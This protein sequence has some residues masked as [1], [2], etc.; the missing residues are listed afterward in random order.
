[1]ADSGTN[2]S[3]AGAEVITGG[4]YSGSLTD[5]ADPADYYRFDIVAGRVIEVSVTSSSNEL[6]AY[7]ADA[8]EQW[9]VQ[10]EGSATETRYMTYQTAYE[11]T[12][13]YCYLKFETNA[14]DI[15]YSFSLTF[16]YSMEGGNGDAPA[17]RIDAFGVAEGPVM[18]KVNS[19]SA[20][21]NNGGEDGMDCYKFWAGEGDRINLS[22][23]A[24]APGL[25]YLN[26]LDPLE[27][28]LVQDLGTHS[29]MTETDEWWTARE[30][31]M[32]YY[33]LEVY[34]DTAPGEYTITLDIMKQDD[35]GNGTD[36][37]GEYIYGLEVPETT[38]I[39]HLEDEDNTDCYVTNAG[40]GDVISVEFRGFS[41]GDA[42]YFDLLDGSGNI[43]RSASSSFADSGQ[44][45]LYYT[46]N[47][48]PVQRYSLKVWMDTE[49][50][51]YVITLGVE[52]QNDA[53]RG[54][55]TPD[56]FLTG[57]ALDNGSYEGWIFDLDQS[58]VYRI[59]AERG[60]IIDINV[61]V[62]DGT[63]V[64]AVIF[65]SE[66][67]SVDSV[68]PNFGEI[69]SMRYC[70]DRSAENGTVYLKVWSGAARYSIGVG[71]YKQNDASSGNDAGAYDWISMD[72]PYPV[73]IDAGHFS[74]YL[75]PEDTADTYVL[76]V[77]AA[78][79][80][81]ITIAPDPG[82]AVSVHLLTDPD[83]EELAS[84]LFNEFGVQAAVEL[85]VLESVVCHLVIAAELG[86]GPY[87]LT[88]QVEDLVEPTAPG[89]P[90]NVIAVAGIG[91]INL[92]WDPPESDGGSPVTYYKL[93]RATNEEGP[94]SYVSAM[95]VTMTLEWS[96]SWD[97]LPGTTYYYMIAAMNAIGQG[98]NSTVVSATLPSAQDDADGDGVPDDQDAF[99]SDPSESVDTDD[100]GEGNNADTD[101]DGDSMPDI[102]EAD[103]GLDPLDPSDA[104]ADPD[105]DGRSNLQEYRDGTDPGTA[106]TDEEN[107][108][109]E[110]P[111]LWYIA[112]GCCCL[113]VILMAVVLL[114]IIVVALRRRKG[115]S[116]E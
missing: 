34:Q 85:D 106:D 52:R 25:L 36:A 76:N 101:D 10:V 58:D 30:T 18:G 104:A 9:L 114:V 51:D 98:G 80:L 29:G 60:D 82:L 99:P 20:F 3:F 48:T 24:L 26:L 79:H 62:N 113:L 73:A 6:S 54:V 115:R 94:Y 64:T 66:L 43:L 69:S 57:I 102:W 88:V 90:L 46:A 28:Y 17:S 13:T 22:F 112:G 7:M 81:N 16:T 61:A 2:D 39:G 75:H 1:M 78:S 33:Y 47:E 83:G 31:P 108:E 11:T 74:G 56:D 105:S 63:N 27:N 109:N 103:N 44:N 68:S 107:E 23:T 95:Y 71:M 67:V 86:F 49:P 93:F 97:M 59:D 38:F 5:P 84:D 91:V 55:D 35:A 8:G 12:Y 92:T 110:D 111:Y 21:P 65:D 15:A 14:G 100:D 50:G 32:G 41:E 87:E 40:N 72:A 96:D 42:L 4:F 37:P 77:P 70:L 89:A 53:Y 45:I 19:G 116:E